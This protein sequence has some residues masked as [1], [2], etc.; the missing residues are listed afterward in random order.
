M[1]IKE[2]PLKSILKKYKKNKYHVSNGNYKSNNYLF[3]FKNLEKFEVKKV[4]FPE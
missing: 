4:K 2:K 3:L 1:K